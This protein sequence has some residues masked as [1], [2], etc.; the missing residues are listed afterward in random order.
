LW[1]IEGWMFKQ[2]LRRRRLH[3]A[4]RHP[5]FHV[6]LQLLLAFVAGMG[7]ELWLVRWAG[8]QDDEHY[9]V[10]KKRIRAFPYSSLIAMQC[11]E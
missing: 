8:G 1:S 5:R 9:M 7:G 10:L 11:T 4:S 2:R 6:I 3:I